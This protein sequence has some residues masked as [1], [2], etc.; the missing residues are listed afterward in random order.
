MKR[1]LYTALRIHRKRSLLQ[2]TPKMSEK[3]NLQLSEKR[4]SLESQGPG[5]HR[6]GELC[7]LPPRQKNGHR[8]RGRR[9]LRG[10]KLFFLFLRPQRRTERRSPR[11]QHHSTPTSSSSGE[12]SRPPSPTTSRPHPEKNRLNENPAD[13]GTG[14]GTFDDITRPENGTRSN[15]SRGTRSQR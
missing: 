15:L 10:R 2:Q 13:G 5:A 6:P 7:C 12:R 8:S 14:A 1:E 4:S 9:K 11:Q 3:R